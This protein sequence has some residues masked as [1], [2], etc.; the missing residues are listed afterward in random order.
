MIRTA[1][2]TLNWTPNAV[3]DVK[4]GYEYEHEK[5]GNDGLTPT[6]TANFSTDAFQ[7][8]NTIFAQDLISLYGG[9]LQ[10]AGG[11]R[12]QF[13]KL[14]TPRFTLTNAPYTNLALSDPPSAY[15]LDGSASYSFV[16][17]NKDPA[18]VGNGYRVPRL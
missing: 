17:R 15:T 13:F 8:S 1:N 9:R 7:S 16:Q 6:G 12:A 5:F 10:I 3:H 18:H 11:F 2:A 14:D 4:F